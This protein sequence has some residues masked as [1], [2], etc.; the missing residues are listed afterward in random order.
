M[1][2]LNN[3]RVG[4]IKTR[5]IWHQCSFHGSD[6]EVGHRTA[7]VP[8]GGRGTT[9]EVRHQWAARYRKTYGAIFSKSLEACVRYP[10]SS[11]PK[12]SKTRPIQSIRCSQCGN[13]LLNQV[14][15]VSFGAVWY[16]PGDGMIFFEW[17]AAVTNPKFPPIPKAKARDFALQVQRS[18]VAGLGGLRCRKW[19]RVA[20]IHGCRNLCRGEISSGVI[21]RWN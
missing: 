6:S 10:E 14:T 18:R 17:E 5:K 3:Q 20:E 12:W 16:K 19:W 13:S 11:H 4:H 8:G 9:W 21:D 7:K 2:M 1:A 15:M